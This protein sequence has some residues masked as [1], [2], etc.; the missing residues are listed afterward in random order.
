VGQI[1]QR[2]RKVFVAAG[3]L[4]GLLLVGG[5]GAKNPEAAKTAPSPFAAEVGE[6]HK[7]KALLEKADHDYKGHRAAA[8]KEL[9]AAIHD[10]A[11]GAHQHPH[12]NPG[13]GNKETQALS[14]AQL[15]EAVEQ[16]RTVHKQLSAAGAPATAAAAVERAIKELHRALEIR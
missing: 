1:Y 8:V 2:G 12:A 15:K 5:A 10:L 16:L 3:V 9:T 6:L 4:L 13:K 14:D 7:V 11:A